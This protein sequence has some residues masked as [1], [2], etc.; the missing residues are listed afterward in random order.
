[1]PLDVI[2]KNGKVYT[3]LQKKWFPDE[4]SSNDLYSVP[5]LLLPEQ[6]RRWRRRPLHNLS[7][8]NLMVREFIYGN[9]QKEFGSAQKRDYLRNN[10]YCLVARNSSSGII[11]D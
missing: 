11:P 10:V 1:M 6:Q 9:D 5:I 8:E 7:S 4:T 2:L 3:V